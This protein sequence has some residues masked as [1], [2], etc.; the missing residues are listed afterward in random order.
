MKPKSTLEWTIRGTY[1][2]ESLCGRFKILE[3]VIAGTRTYT[4]IIGEKIMSRRLFVLDKNTGKMHV[5]LPKEDPTL[6]AH[7]IV[8]SETV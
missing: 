8:K 1:E 5:L 6:F 4:T 2:M 7:E 3:R